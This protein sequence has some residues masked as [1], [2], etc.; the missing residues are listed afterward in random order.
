VKLFFYFGVI[1]VMFSCSSYD[2]QPSAYVK[3]ADE[4]TAKTA[5]K[6][7]GEKGLILVGTGGQMMDDIQML[8]MGFHFYK[9]VDI[10]TARQLV[11]D[12]VEEYLSAINV[13]KEVRPYLHNFPFTAQNVQLVIYFYKPDRSKVPSGKIKIAAAEEGKVVYYIDCPKEHTLKSIYEETYED[14]WKVVNSKQ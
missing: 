1:V 3:M 10:G 6:L 2:Y 7:R 5:Q 4:I 14:A 11:V 12:S 8:M 9:E 13:N